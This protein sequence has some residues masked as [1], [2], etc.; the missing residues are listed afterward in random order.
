MTSMLRKLG[1][2]ARPSA[3]AGTEL[4]R[5]FAGNYFSDEF[6]EWLINGISHLSDDLI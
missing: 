2:V 5:R 1:D 3:T 6:P 4:G